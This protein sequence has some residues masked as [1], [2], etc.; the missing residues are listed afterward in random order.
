MNL[1]EWFTNSPELLQSIPEDDRGSGTTTKVLGLTWNTG[2]D[3]L[4]CT[5]LPPPED[6]PATKRR[7]LRHLAKLYDPCGFFCAINI[8]GKIL[9]QDLWRGDYG[10]DEVVP[11]DVQTSWGS[12]VPD[13]AGVGRRVNRTIPGSHPQ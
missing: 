2:E 10:W 7:I 9:L 4:R 12:L 3:T 1:R 5:L 8:R 6:Q 11:P 13:L